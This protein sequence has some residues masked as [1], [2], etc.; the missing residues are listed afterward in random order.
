MYILYIL[1]LYTST[2][3]AGYV[4]LYTSTTQRDIFLFNS[5]KL[6]VN[7]LLITLPK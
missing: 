4:P 6:I 1:Y 2:L 3:S 7:M 5:Q